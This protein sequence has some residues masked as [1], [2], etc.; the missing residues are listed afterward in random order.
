MRSKRSWVACVGMSMG[1]SILM[2]T[3]SSVA[4]R[5]FAMLARRSEDITIEY[6]RRLRLRP[7]ERCQQIGRRV[8]EQEVHC[9]AVWP[10]CRCVSVFF[11]FSV[12]PD[13]IAANFL[14]ETVA[15]SDE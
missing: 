11:G 7:L 3:W 2:L 1:E 14:N 4:A 15:G 5:R 9:G 13:G 8:A 10:V 6:S 12:Q